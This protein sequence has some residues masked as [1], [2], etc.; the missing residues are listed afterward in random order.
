[1]FQ[2]LQQIKTACVHPGPEVGHFPLKSLNKALLS[3]PS[4]MLFQILG[5][6]QLRGNKRKG[7]Q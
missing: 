3:P 5:K 7:T 2:C 4:Y 1:M 6:I